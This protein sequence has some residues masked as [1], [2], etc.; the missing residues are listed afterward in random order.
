MVCSD[1]PQITWSTR[2][3][4]FNIP[5][6]PVL[7]ARH[8]TGKKPRARPAPPVGIGAA[9]PQA[10]SPLWRGICPPWKTRDCADLDWIL[11]CT[12]DSRRRLAGW[13]R[14]S[15]HRRHRREQDGTM[16]QLLDKADRIFLT[17]WLRDPFGLV[18]QLRHRPILLSP[19]TPVA[20]ASRPPRKTAT[21]IRRAP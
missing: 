4:K 5:H 11:R 13:A 15:G 3:K 9:T 10:A 6:P 14:R 7:Q 18:E 1:S 19:V 20:R 16:A 8:P 2:S 17:R 12:A 21:R